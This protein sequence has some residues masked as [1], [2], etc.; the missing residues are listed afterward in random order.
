MARPSEIPAHQTLLV[1]RKWGMGSAEGATCSRAAGI[2]RTNTG[3]GD[4]TDSTAINSNRCCN[5]SHRSVGLGVG[6]GVDWAWDVARRRPTGIL[7]ATKTEMAE[8]AWCIYVKRKD[9]R[10]PLTTLET[11]LSL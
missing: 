2:G 9:V 11:F 8:I 4:P 3:V 10:Q 5:P 7:P 1:D 6:L